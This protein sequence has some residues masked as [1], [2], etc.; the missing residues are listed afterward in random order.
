[1]SHSRMD[2]RPAVRTGR[3]AGVGP[4]VHARARVDKRTKTLC[5]RLKR[6]EIAVID[7]ADLDSAAAYSLVECRPALVINA[8]QA[9]TGRYPNG[10]PA[11]LLQARIPMLDDCGPELLDVLRE[12][13]HLDV[14][15]EEIW[16]DGAPIAKG[17]LMTAPRLEAALK[18]AELNLVG[19]L[20]AFARNTLEYLARER[21]MAVAELPLPAL[22]TPI[23]G[24]PALVVVRGSGYK[25]DLD[26]VRPWIREQ[27]PVIIA[28]DGGA[29]ALLDAGLKPHILLGDMDSA[30]DASLRCGAELVVHTYPDHRTSPGKERLE[31]LGLTALELPAPGV[32]EDVA[33]LMAQ[34]GGAS[35]IVAVGTH[36]SMVEFLDKR[37]RGMASTFLT[38]L[39]VG[40]ILVDAKGLSRLYRPALTGGMVAGV[41]LAAAVPLLVIVASSPAAQR[42]LGLI[43]MSLEVW[44]RRQ[45]MR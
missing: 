41:V 35:L 2:D 20:E 5:R 37:R 14:R 43:R 8:A 40:S 11:I 28:V 23:R 22:R 38:R 30:S 18:A 26:R 36:F 4:R 45:G 19:E 29:D 21:E 34:Q 27:R 44:L 12:G 10:G 39:R 6:G 32:S 24:R 7:H 1:M 33:M 25:Q 13:Q 17:R 9:I 31:S 3:G 16:A 15:G 42:W